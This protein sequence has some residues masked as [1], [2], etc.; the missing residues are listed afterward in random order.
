MQKKWMRPDILFQ[1]RAVFIDQR[2]RLAG[3]VAPGKD[4]KVGLLNGGGK[5]DE[6]GAFYLMAIGPLLIH[7]IKAGNPTKALE[8]QFHGARRAGPDA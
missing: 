1:R 8:V 4:K 5:R 2:Q 3:K 7:S 6:A